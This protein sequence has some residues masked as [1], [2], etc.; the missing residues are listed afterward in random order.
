MM[1]PLS[2]E[3]IR[4]VYCGC[5]MTDDKVITI[6]QHLYKLNMKHVHLYRMVKHDDSIT[7]QK[8][9]ITDLINGIDMIQKFL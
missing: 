9:D 2:N 7:L 1:I 8:K 6:A 3:C 4:N 5:N